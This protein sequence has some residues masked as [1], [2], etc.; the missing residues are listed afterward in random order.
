VSLGI[1]LETV[2]I[3]VTLDKI[4][5]IAPLC[6]STGDAGNGIK[7]GLQLVR[8]SSHLLD[9]L[10]DSTLLKKLCHRAEAPALEPRR[11]QWGALHGIPLV[12]FRA[13]QG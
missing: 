6:N 1:T 7:L 2:R 8:T 12:L 13:N 4:S 10:P 9:A 11:P 3:M 5:L